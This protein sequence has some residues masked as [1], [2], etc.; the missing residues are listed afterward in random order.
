MSCEKPVWFISRGSLSVYQVKPGVTAD[1][2]AIESSTSS[3]SNNDSSSSSFWIGRMLWIVIDWTMIRMVG[4]W[5]FLLVQAH[6][7]SPGQ[8]AIKRLLLLF[9]Q[10]IACELDMCEEY[11]ANICGS[12]KFY[13]MCS[14]SE[15]ICNMHTSDVAWAA[16]LATFSCTQ[17]YHMHMHML[18]IL[19]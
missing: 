9:V 3:S 11:S 8:R 4:G 19:K 15:A 5:M 14:A 12:S 1:K 7:G 13:R 16:F 18:L 17:W 10:M 6:L 2:K